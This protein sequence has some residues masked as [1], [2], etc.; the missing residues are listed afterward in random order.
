LIRAPFRTANPV[1]IG[2]LRHVTIRLKVRGVHFKMLRFRYLCSLGFAAALTSSAYALDAGSSILSTFDLTLTSPNSGVSFLSNNP[3]M[4]A[5][6]MNA[7]TSGG[8]NV[9]MAND[10][11]LTSNN[12]QYFLNMNGSSTGRAGSFNDA[13]FLNLQMVNTNSTATTVHLNYDLN[14]IL[15]AD[16]SNVYQD[17]NGYF[18]GSASANAGFSLFTQDLGTVSSQGTAVAVAG[19]SHQ[20]SGDRN[21]GFDLTVAANSSLTLEFIPQNTAQFNPGPVPEPASMAVLGI[22]ALF[23]KRRKSAKGGA[24]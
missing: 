2:P 12:F 4:G 11:G 8:S 6:T 21:G 13:G 5:V 15:N 22:G 9:S 24:K 1:P 17:K 18:N 20:V 16:A 14:Y 19:T 3:N 10:Y 7:T 23:L